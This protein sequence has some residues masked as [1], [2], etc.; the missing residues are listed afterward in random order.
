M[1]SEI[2]DRIL[3]MLYC[4]IVAI[5]RGKCLEAENECKSLFQQLEVAKTSVSAYIEIVCYN[6]TLLC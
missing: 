1:R 6:D 3:C 5:E 4:Y 2:L